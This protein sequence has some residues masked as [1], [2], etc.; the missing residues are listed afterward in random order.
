MSITNLKQSFRQK[1]PCFGVF[2]SIPSTVALEQLVLAGYDFVILDL[3]HTL[4]DPSHIDILL[5][6][7]RHYQMDTLV[8]IPCSRLDW[9]APLL[10]AGATG[11]IAANVQ[12]VSQAQDL[13]RACYY[14]PQGQRGLNSTRLNGYATQDL[15]Q[16]LQT[17]NQHTVVVAMI[18]SM[19][20]LEHAADIAAIDGLDAILEGAA[21]LSQSMGLPWQTSH[22]DVQSALQ[23]L[24]SQCQ[25]QCCFIALPRQAESIQ[26]WRDRGIHHFVI[27]DDRSLMRRAHQQ[28][29][30]AFTKEYH[31]VR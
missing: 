3:E 31:H 5:M 15:P 30:H 25:S 22:P 23:Q 16:S 1:Q 26:A 10:D 9:V 28:H 18:E 11:I 14:H 20:G 12:Q 24:Q 17:A 4:W 19:Q 8:R 2:C 7:A 13:V 29:L 6:T 21:D 27:G